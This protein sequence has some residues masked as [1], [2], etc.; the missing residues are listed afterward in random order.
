MSR[1][2]PPAVTLPC[3]PIASSNESGFGQTLSALHRED[4]LETL[5]VADCIRLKEA[6][7]C[8][9]W[10]LSKAHKLAHLGHWKYMVADGSV[11]WSEEIFEI[12]GLPPDGPPP[13]R[14]DRERMHTAESWARLEAAIQRAIATGEPYE[15]DIELVRADGEH[16]WLTIHGEAER[17]AVGRVERII[18]VAQDITE[19]KR[20]EA[21]LR[22]SEARLQEAQSLCSVGDWELDRDSAKMTWSREVFR[23]F[24]RPESLGIPDLNEAMSYYPPDSLERTR[25]AFWHAIDSGERCTL[26]HDIHL[27]SGEVRHHAT[28]IVP[29]AD[30]SGRVCKL[31]GTVQDITARKRLELERTAQHGHLAELS[32][33]LVEIQER[34]RRQLAGELHDRASPNLAA[35]QLTVSNLTSALPP[36]VLAAVEPLLDDIN[37]LLADTTTGIREIS[38][39]LRPA[40]LDYAGL[41]PALQ[42]YAE[43]FRRRSGIAVTLDSE[44]CD[45]PLSADLQSVLFRIVQEALTNCAKHASAGSIRIRLSH[46][47]RELTMSIVDNGVGFDP[48]LLIEP[49][50]L[51]GLGLITMRERAEFAG[52]RFS[53]ASRR[54]EGTEVRVSFDRHREAP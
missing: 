50:S 34:E 46:D 36:D 29:I 16:R 26:E 54:G 10:L 47:E 17:D 41:L 33:R 15:L 40:I 27:P 14:A 30:A 9:A 49:G 22:A 32:R 45:M 20:I 51:A 53:I 23:L 3:Q 18:G 21:A 1:N 48:M 8:R 6:L 5:D 19:R 43:Q 24:D 42:D 25:D 35:L 11:Y 28:V 38:T 13:S 7:W 4:R 12:L 37:A 44:E 39:E 31:F 2:R 52:G